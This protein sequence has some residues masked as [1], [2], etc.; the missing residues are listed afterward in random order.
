MNH[1]RKLGYYKVIYKGEK[2]VAEYNGLV[3]Y[4]PGHECSF[5]D[6][7]FDWIDFKENRIYYF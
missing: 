5:N 2:Y 4:L 6:E 1:F 7:I 3:W